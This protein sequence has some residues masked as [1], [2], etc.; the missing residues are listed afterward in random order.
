M[1]VTHNDS[2][3]E[4]IFFCSLSEILNEIAL[5]STI[6]IIVSEIVIIEIKTNVNKKK[7][8]VGENY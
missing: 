6:F 8:N 1:F 7:M 3:Q 2:R 5:R 4:E